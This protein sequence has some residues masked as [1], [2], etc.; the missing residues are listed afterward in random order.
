MLAAGLLALEHERVL[1][2]CSSPSTMESRC[3]ALCLAYPDAFITGPTGGRLTGLRR[4]PPPE[5]IHLEIG[6]G[7]NI[8]PFV[9]VVLRQ[10]TKIHP[11]DVQARRKDGI[12]LAS[13]PRLA[14]DLGAD[15]SE[16][17]PRV[18]GRA[19]APRAP[20]HVGLAPLSRVASDAPWA[21]GF[22]HRRSC[23]R[24][25]AGSGAPAASHPEVAVVD[26]LRSID[27]PAVVQQRR[28]DLPNGSPAW[29]DI[30]VPEIGWGIEIDV[31]PDHLL[32][33]GT[34]RDKARD[35]QCHLIGWQIDRI[36]PLDLLDLP[37]VALE[38]KALYM[39]RLAQR[40][41]A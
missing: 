28:L 7:H 19:V 20:M 34:T 30:A 22:A 21:A 17:D 26:A 32:L 1:R 39:V 38:L 4:M 18:G 14:F 9:G 41:A 13:P 8:G 31:H 15:L 37:G 5:P 40:R 25:A 33:E 12:R 10:S 35:R 23:A 16:R 36:T 29:I 2:I 24:G 27:V 11:A 6:H 3:T